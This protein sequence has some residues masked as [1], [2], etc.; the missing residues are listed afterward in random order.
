MNFSS[1]S[2]Q[3]PEF[4]WAVVIALI[5]AVVSVLTLSFQWRKDVKEQHVKEAAGAST[6]SNILFDQYQEE[7]DKC[8]DDRMAFRRERAEWEVERKE[9]VDKVYKLED[10][11][12]FLNAQLADLKREN[13][14][15]QAAVSDLQQRLNAAL[16]E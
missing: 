4:P 14:A 6:A 5:G 1:A 2:Q 7:L 13:K 8:R 16:N 15:L 9:L 11:R 12:L 10:E 3:T